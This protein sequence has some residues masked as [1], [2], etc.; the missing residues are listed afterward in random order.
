MRVLV[1]ILTVHSKGDSTAKA[2]E[3]VYQSSYLN[4]TYNI[5]NM[6]PSQ[7]R[8]QS[9][10]FNRLGKMYVS[11][12]HP[13]PFSNFRHFPGQTPLAEQYCNIMEDIHGLNASKPDVL[14][15]TMQNAYMKAT[16]G[17]Y[18]EALE[19]L[20]QNNPAPL[21][22]LRLDQTFLGFAA[23]IHLRRSLHR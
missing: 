20:R 5:G 3:Q 14:N 8:L 13:L 4:A 12:Q 7:L 10:I 22:T 23:M 17:R 6:I 21:K 15:T 19:M 9:A 1:T 18:S 11:T 16:A 2:L